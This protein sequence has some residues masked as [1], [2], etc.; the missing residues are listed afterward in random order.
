VVR[1][2]IVE[3][4]KNW[5]CLRDRGSTT[6][7]PI[8]NAFQSLLFPGCSSARPELLPWKQEAVGSNPTTL[9]I[10]R[11]LR[12]SVALAPIAQLAERTAYTRRELR[13]GARLE[14][15]VLLGV[16]S[17]SSMEERPLRSGGRVFKS[18]RD[19]QTEGGAQRCAT[20]LESRADLRVEGSTPSPSAKLT[21]NIR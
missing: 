9:T 5:C 16:L 19:N 12:S 11:M 13:T 4:S 14:V 6:Q 20:G 3:P 21:C 15:R 2:A 18:R 17:R 7:C 10:S 1:L 8:A